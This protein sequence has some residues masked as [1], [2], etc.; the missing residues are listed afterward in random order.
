MAKNN[1]L[2]QFKEI[3][4]EDSKSGLMFSKKETIK[5]T[6]CVILFFYSSYLSTR[7]IHPERVRKNNYKY[8]H[9]IVDIVTQF[10]NK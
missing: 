6:R 2:S 4:T 3:T 7:N 10:S 1:D 8:I 5:S 9:V